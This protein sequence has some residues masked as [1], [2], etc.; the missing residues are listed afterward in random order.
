MDYSAHYCP[1]LE[2]YIEDNICF[3]IVCVAEK[4]APA[5]TAPQEAFLK[6]GSREICLNCEH[7]KNN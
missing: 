7:N 5:W 1:I 2:K 3:D 6:S 4:E